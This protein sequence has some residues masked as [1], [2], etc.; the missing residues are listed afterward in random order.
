[1]NTKKRFSLCAALLYICLVLTLLSL[2]GCALQDWSRDLFHGKE[3]G[4]GLFTITDLDGTWPT[5]EILMAVT[6]EA[7]TTNAEAALIFSSMFSSIGD[8]TVSETTA[9]VN[10]PIVADEMYYILLKASETDTFYKSGSPVEI[11]NNSGT[12]A[13]SDFIIIP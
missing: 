9:T 1:M 7:P 8:F 13:W 11:T 4:D 5:G 10:M 3:S 6:T 2:A 12:A